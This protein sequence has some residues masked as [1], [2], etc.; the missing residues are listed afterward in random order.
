MSDDGDGFELEVVVLVPPWG[1]KKGSSVADFKEGEFV[2]HFCDVW[3]C[4]LD[5]E[6]GDVGS[7][8]NTSCMIRFSKAGKR[9]SRS[10]MRK[11]HSVNFGDVS[12]ELE[13]GIEGTKPD[14]LELGSVLVAAGPT[15]VFILGGGV[16]NG[17]D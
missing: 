8:F 7:S 11:R 15:L 9:S 13:V 10:L 12:L 5:T 14:E 17:V 3:L 6:F 16:L 2:G 1:E 4:A